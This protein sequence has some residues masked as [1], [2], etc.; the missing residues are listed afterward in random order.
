[1]GTRA[2]TTILLR[3]I[4]DNMG[5][6]RHGPDG[7]HGIS[8]T[9]PHHLETNKQDPHFYSRYH[10]DDTPGIEVLA[11]DV[12][13]IPDSGKP[14]F[15]FC[16]MVGVLISHIQACCARAVIIVPDTKAPWFL[17]LGNT[18]VR[19]KTLATKADPNVFFRIH[20]SRGTI[21]VVFQKWGM[22]AV[23]VDVS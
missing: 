14:C 16:F 20:H 21:P 12:S 10:T 6:L 15:G 13:K 9:P 11:Q 3:Q 19:T 8:S 2:P 18:L 23:E 1:M 7:F 4:V 17:L 22:I 5:R